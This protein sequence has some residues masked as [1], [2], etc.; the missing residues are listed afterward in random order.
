VSAPWLCGRAVMTHETVSGMLMLARSAPSSSSRRRLLG[1]LA[2]LGL[3]VLTAGC[4][5]KLSIIPTPS[6]AG[7]ARRNKPAPLAP[8]KAPGAPSAPI[9]AT[10]G[11]VVTLEGVTIERDTVTAG[12]YLRIWLHWQ[13][14]AQSQDDLRSIGRIVAGNGRVL[15]SEDDQIGGRKRHLSR[16]QVGERVVDEMRVRVT[17]SSAPG[18][19]EIAIGVLQPDN[20]TAVP[21]SGRAPTAATWQEDAILVGTIEVLA[22]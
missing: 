2:V 16:W 12:D 10:F 14:T 1:G 4:D 18:E 6:A 7:P 19:Y 8:A 11:R 17:P 5:R 21:V 22:G 13:S 3:S 20:L 9:G 15:A